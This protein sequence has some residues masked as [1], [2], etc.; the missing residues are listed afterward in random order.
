MI[1]DYYQ[2]PTKDIKSRQFFLLKKI[3]GSDP[4]PNLDPDTIFQDWICVS[5]SVKNWTG[6]AT[7]LKWQI[8][9]LVVIVFPEVNVTKR[10]KKT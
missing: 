7:L 9:D 5:G 2:G 8:K 1:R 3:K 4:D 6:S 10:G